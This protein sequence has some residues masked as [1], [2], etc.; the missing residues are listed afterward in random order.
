[1]GTP[2]LSADPSQGAYSFG[3]RSQ[4]S[5]LRILTH[6]LNEI[7]RIRRQFGASHEHIQ[8]CVEKGALRQETLH[9]HVDRR[10]LAIEGQTC[11]IENKIDALE[12]NLQAIQS[13]LAY[14]FRMDFCSD[15]EQDEP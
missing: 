9:S 14:G 10:L 3:K 1:M 8:Q 12:R 13:Q 15:S 7:S 4:S 6:L 11:T 5:L 2:L